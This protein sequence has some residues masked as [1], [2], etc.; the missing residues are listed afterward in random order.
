MNFDQFKRQFDDAFQGGT[1]PAQAGQPARQEIDSDLA[2]I[3]Q[4]YGPGTT[5]E[6]WEVRHGL[7]A[8]RRKLRQLRGGE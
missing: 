8:A 7:A 1:V 4:A 6:E 2:E 3:I 5:P